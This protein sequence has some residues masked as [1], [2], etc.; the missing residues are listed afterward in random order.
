[1]SESELDA[2]RTAVRNFAQREVAPRVREYDLEERLP[3]DIL[4][5]MARL[6][7]F[8][9]MVPEA[10]GGAGMDHVTFSACIEEISKV[11]HCLGVLMSMPSALVGAGLLTYGTD[12]QRKQWLA[13]LARGEIFGGAG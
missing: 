8:G 6:D 11:D 3:R 4:D 10:W 9:G 1:M 12:E 7:L 2:M 13:P 5:G